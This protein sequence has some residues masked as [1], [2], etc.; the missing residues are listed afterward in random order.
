MF[1]IGEKVR[2]KIG[3]GWTV[4]TVEALESQGAK[5]RI[6]TRDGNLVSRPVAN[7]EKVV[8]DAATEPAS[9]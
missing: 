9:V 4:G 3:R 6:R 7:C 8:G 2:Y 5:L 1:A